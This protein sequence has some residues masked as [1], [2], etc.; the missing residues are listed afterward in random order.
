MKGQY[1]LVCRT[2][3]KFLPRQYSTSALHR[4][5][6][7]LDAS[8]KVSARAKH[9]PSHFAE[10]LIFLQALQDDVPTSTRWWG[11][12][13]SKAGW[14]VRDECTSLALELG[15]KPPLAVEE[16][17]LC[18]RRTF[19][20]ASDAALHLQNHHYAVRANDIAERPPGIQ[21]INSASQGHSWR[22]VGLFADQS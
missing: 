20:T 16:S 8:F 14:V 9:C 1:S 6:G 3:D 5:W 15:I 22:S 21:V 2:I 4:I 19:D 7:S 12:A 13:K 11:G 10:P 18:Q 17:C